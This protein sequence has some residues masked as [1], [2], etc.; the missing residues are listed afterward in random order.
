MKNIFLTEK[1]SYGLA[2]SISR[3]ISHAFTLVAPRASRQIFTSILLNPFS[4]RR[5]EFKQVQPAEV[6]QVKM[7]MGQLNLSYFPSGARQILLSHGWMDNSSR[8][9]AL[10]K[11]LVSAGYSCWCMDH[12]GHGKSEGNRS[13]IYGFREGLERVIQHIETVSGKLDGLVCHSMSGVALLNMDIKLL[14]GK[15]KILI[16]TP[17]NFF[18]SMFSK[19]KNAG[20]SGKVLENILDYISDT[21]KTHWKRYR[22]S[23]QLKKIDGDFLFIHD[24]YDKF[25]PYSLTHSILGTTDAGLVTTKKLGHSKMVK[26]P[27]VFE[28]IKQFLES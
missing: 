8:F 4:R 3:S 22:P 20:L 26:K 5:Y 13:H 25:A 19:V 14:K 9:D 28:K 1:K 21:Y 15:K 12:I 27:I 17:F 6:Y 16:G 23:K 18:E 24:K 10:V 2:K 7:S 11:N